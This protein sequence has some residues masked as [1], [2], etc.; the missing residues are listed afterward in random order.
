MRERESNFALAGCRRRS[1]VAAAGPIVSSL[2]RDPPLH[3]NRS[4]VTCPLLGNRFDTAFT[5]R[6]HITF[7]VT[8]IL[9]I[10]SFFSDF[11]HFVKV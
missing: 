5:L 2:K 6:T 9:V 3:G 10:E 8:E 4:Q 11:M 1:R 7:F